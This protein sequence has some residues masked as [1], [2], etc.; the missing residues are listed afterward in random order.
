MKVLKAIFLFYK[1]LLIWSLVANIIISI[2]MPQFG[3]ALIVKFVIILV[4]YRVLTENQQQI[5]SQV[6]NQL[7]LTLKRLLIY[8]FLI[9]IT[10][11]FSYLAVVKEFI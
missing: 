3:S 6:F 4:L 1:P 2:L 11:T 9:D 5:I 8:I 10:F 7:G